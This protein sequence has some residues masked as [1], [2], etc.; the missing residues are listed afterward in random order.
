MSLDLAGVLELRT[1]RVGDHVETHAF[2]D[3]RALRLTPRLLDA[4]ALLAAGRPVAAA[5]VEPLIALGVLRPRAAPDAG[6]LAAPAARVAL[7]GDVV[8]ECRQPPQPSPDGPVTAEGA[9]PLSMFIAPP[10]LGGMQAL[11]RVLRHGWQQMWRAA[12]ARDTAADPDVVADV[13]ARIARAEVERDADLAAAFTI[14]TPARLRPRRPL[15]DDAVHFPIDSLLIARDRR[16]RERGLPARL[17]RFPDG[18]TGAHLA[19]AGA[20]LGALAAGLD[21][22]ALA[23]WLARAPELTPLYEALVAL[24]A[25]EPAPPAPTLTAAPGEVVHLGHA[26]L[27]ANL[28][29]AHVVVDPWLP[30][31]SRLDPAPPPAVAALPPLA[32][33]FITHHHWDHVHVDTLLRLPKGTPIYVPRQDATRP[34]WPRTERLLAML[35]FS[36]VRALGHGEAVDLGDGGRVTA[37]P[38]TGEDPCELVWVGNTYVLAHAGRAALVHVDASPD[39]HGA[40]TVSRGVIAGLRA[41]HG[42]LSPVFATRRQELAGML[43]YGWEALLAPARAWVEPTENCATGGAFLAALCRD[44]GARE[45]V[46]Y[47]EGGGTWFP[48]WTNFIPVA[49]R[50]ALAEPYQYLWEPLDEIAA[51]VRAAGATTTLSAPGARYVIGGPPA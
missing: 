22:G 37:A 8:V 43:D 42:A 28:G 51:R 31:A 21:H 11:A 46:L 15:Q 35:G 49:G 36:D 40:S 16:W 48:P 41:A 17:V 29:G 34:V 44:A 1:A 14:D 50:E 39:R 19:T 26:T 47:S 24:D 27:L 7:R 18:G 5:D 13:L 3:G 38:F 6:P 45:L 20:L 33:I 32:A 9:A 23:A 10:L 2:L 4:L 30:P 12:I 25:L